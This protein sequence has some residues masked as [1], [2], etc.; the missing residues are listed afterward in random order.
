MRGISLNSRTL[1]EQAYEAIKDFIIKNELKPGQMISIKSL[2]ESIGISQTPI[3]EAVLK[4]SRDGFIRGEPHKQFR[5]TEI[6]EGDVHQIY[7]VRRLLEPHAAMLAAM[8]IKTDTELKALLEDVMKYA[9]EIISTPVGQIQINDYLKIDF[10][11]NEI[12]LKSVFPFLRDVL[13][14]V[15]DCSLRIRT[16]AE[17][18]S[19][20]LRR[21]VLIE[22]TEEH[23][24]IIRAIHGECPEES[25]A[26][27]L[28][29]LDNGET[30]TLRAIRTI[31]E[32]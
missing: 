20:T 21:E 30:R 14:F 23:L 31:L 12:F 4:L 7:E 5:V 22:I 32:Q 24:E 16:F 28:K 25:K 17:T 29:H 18:A 10:K 13:R 1:S 11:L 6:G 27:V 2:A 19:K 3:R 9:Q 8:T 26:K 15:S